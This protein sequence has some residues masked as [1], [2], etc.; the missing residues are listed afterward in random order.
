MVFTIE[1]GI[2]I[3]EE[4]VGVRIEDVVYVD[5]SGR[6]VDLIETLPHESGSIEAA[7]RR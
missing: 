2:Y 6:L 3:P 5:E 7:M 4:K 1:P